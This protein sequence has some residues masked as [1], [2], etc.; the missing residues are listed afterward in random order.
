MALN[1][2]SVTAAIDEGEL[3]KM[4]IPARV[5]FKKKGFVNFSQTNAGEERE[6]QTLQA[7]P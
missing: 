5:S 1:G 4:T 7:S 3:C 2:L 6:T